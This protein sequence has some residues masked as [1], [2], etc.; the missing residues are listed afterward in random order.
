ME[1]PKV[2]EVGVCG[3]PDEKSNE[4]VKAFI[5]RSDDS[6]TEE[7]IKEF[8]R[9]KLTNYKIPKHIAFRDE[10]PKSNVGK[11]LRRKLK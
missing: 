4:A 6:L 5:V 8:C 9:Q 3:V 7:E 10:L 2:R 1:N 11:I